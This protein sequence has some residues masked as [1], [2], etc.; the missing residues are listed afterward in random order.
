MHANQKF[1]LY[2]MYSWLVQKTMQVFER[3]CFIAYKGNQCSHILNVI[4]TT[5]VHTFLWHSASACTIATTW[6][7]GKET[8]YISKYILIR[9]LIAKIPVCFIWH[10]QNNIT[11]K[12]TYFIHC[13][14]ITPVNTSLF[15]HFTVIS[16]R[17]SDIKVD[18]SEHINCTNL[19]SISEP[20]NTTNCCCCYWTTNSDWWSTLW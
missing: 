4:Y 20:V 11:H 14:T 19:I 16:S 8:L 17:S 5:S 10:F 7:T 6:I 13:K 2:P 15:S 18:T 3:E 9:F 1:D 12:L